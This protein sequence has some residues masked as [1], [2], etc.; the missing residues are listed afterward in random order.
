MAKET[1]EKILDTAERLFAKRGIDGVSIRAITGEAKVNLAAIHYHFGSKEALVKEVFARRIGAVNRDRLRLL[2]EY[3]IR[4]E[5]AKPDLEEL[6][7]IFV[8]PPLRLLES[9]GGEIFMRVF[10]RIFAEASEQL[11][12]MLVDLFK[13]VF[14]KFS[15]AFEKAAPQIPKQELIWRFQFLIGAMAHTMLHGEL[16]N[17]FSPRIV[18]L[19][20]V[21]SNIERLTKFGTAGLIAPL[22]EEIHDP[23]FK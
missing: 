13:E 4:L 17:K 9:E 20:D 11:R 5:S 6:V 1:R 23:I 8:G 19:S 22:T 7:R 21:E 3:T 14:I 15:A 18:E 10:G 12:S 2:E 16:F